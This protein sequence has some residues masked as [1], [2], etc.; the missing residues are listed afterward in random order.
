MVS[1][2]IMVIW[3][4]KIKYF[5]V[6][7]EILVSS[8]IPFGN[9]VFHNAESSLFDCSLGSNKNPFWS[10]INLWL[11]NPSTNLILD[12]Y[13]YIFKFDSKN[14]LQTLKPYTLT[15]H[16]FLS[17]IFTKFIKISKK[18]YVRLVLVAIFTLT[19]Y[20]KQKYHLNLSRLS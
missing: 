7:S 9:R 14:V 19:D 6:K 15:F 13:F 20:F 18:S 5:I 3:F 11:K 1:W 17:K 2:S 10:I 12:Q 16:L 4:K 8:E